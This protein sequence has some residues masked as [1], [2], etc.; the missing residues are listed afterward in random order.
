MDVKPGF[1]L[2]RFDEVHLQLC[3]FHRRHRE[4]NGVNVIGENVVVEGATGPGRHTDPVRSALRLVENKLNM[5]AADVARNVAGFVNNQLDS[6]L[7]QETILILA[8][9]QN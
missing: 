3:A 9:L 7:E 6:V 5:A 1:F 8:Q 2:R 4:P